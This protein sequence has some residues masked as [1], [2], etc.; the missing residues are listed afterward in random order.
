MST[1]RVVKSSNYSII[2][3]TVLNDDRIS[4][5][6]KGLAA[7]LLS[8]PDDWRIN[9]A[10][11]W[12][13]SANGHGSVKRTL[14]ELETAGYLRRTRTR[15][16]NGSF[17][18]DHALYEIPQVGEEPE[19]EEGTEGL[20]ELE[21][22]ET[23]ETADVSTTGR[24][25]STGYPSTGKP[26]NGNHRMETIG[27]KP[28]DILSTED[29]VLIPSTEE[30]QQRAAAEPPAPP[31]AAAAPSVMAELPEQPATT[32]T[33]TQQPAIVAYH[34]IFL[35]Y[36]SKAQM[37]QILRH[38]IDDT[39]RWN[40]VLGAW[41]RSGYNPRN[42]GGMLDWYDNPERMETN[43]RSTSQGRASPARSKVAASMQAIDDVMAMIERGES[44]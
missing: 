41:C 11:L 7:Y 40:E 25:P 18:W 8:K 5:E 24:F 38:G 6:A 16:P 26:S 14:R 33:L 36:P 23:T 35:A 9:T 12:K 31:P 2:N 43:G 21:E 20:E 39:A 17:E 32:K 30:G 13:A 4:W 3:N 37:T 19:D 34:D 10:Q 1:I 27:W 28:S 44:T 15:R 42:I 29:Q 22:P